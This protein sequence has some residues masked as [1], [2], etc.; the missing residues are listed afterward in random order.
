MEGNSNE[1]SHSRGRIPNKTPLVADSTAGKHPCPTQCSA[2]SQS[3]HDRQPTIHSQ[4]QDRV[5][6]ISP[7]AQHRAWPLGPHHPQN[8][9]VLGSPRSPNIDETKAGCTK[10]LI[11][12]KKKIRG[13]LSLKSAMRES[14]EM[15]LCAKGAA[16]QQLQ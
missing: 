6:E 9:G 3:E 12:R 15:A 13:Y 11:Y 10:G 5:R 7:P 8:R 4:V 1:N 14:K 16:L 2:C